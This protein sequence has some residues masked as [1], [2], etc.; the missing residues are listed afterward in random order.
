MIFSL[1]FVPLNLWD[2]LLEVDIKN[3]ATLAATTVGKCWPHWQ[4]TILRLMESDLHWALGGTLWALFQG[5]Q[6]VRG[7]SWLHVKNG[8]VNY[9]RMTGHGASL[10]QEVA[11]LIAAH[12]LLRISILRDPH[13]DGCVTKPS[14]SHEK[15]CVR[16]CSPTHPDK[17]LQKSS[18]SQSPQ[19]IWFQISPSIVFWASHRPPPT[20]NPQ[21]WGIILGFPHFLRRNTRLEDH[22]I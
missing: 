7:I 1:E 18:Y 8:P 19:K 11:A 4:V 14:C 13:G 5:C 16:K 3:L 22:P 2:V 21:F 12:K 10:G 20:N 9:L 6:V 17:S 15:N